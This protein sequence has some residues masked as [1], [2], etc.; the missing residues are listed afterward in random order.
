[1]LPLATELKSLP[2]ST[3]IWATRS[4]QVESMTA[5]I[6]NMAGHLA[7]GGALVTGFEL[8]RGYDLD[9]YDADCRAAGLAGAAR[10]ATWDGEP[11]QAGGDYAV[12][13]HRP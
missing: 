6:A 7:P 4:G 5:V 11:W 12:S 1:M 8:G 10:F 2:R 9:R 13:I 3:F